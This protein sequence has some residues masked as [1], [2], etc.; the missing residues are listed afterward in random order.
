VTLAARS[1]LTKGGRPPRNKGL[2]LTEGMADEIKNV[3]VDGQ[4]FSR[5]SGLPHRDPLRVL[6]QLRDFDAHA[7][8]YCSVG[9]ESNGHPGKPAMDRYRH[10]LD[11]PRT[12]PGLRHEV[13]S[14]QRGDPVL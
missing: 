5:Y 2:G 8:L 4:P 11:L 6:D 13:A 9:A 3:V 12:C 14:G 10:K 1:E 7:D